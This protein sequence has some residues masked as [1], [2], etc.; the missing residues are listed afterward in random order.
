MVHYWKNT[1]KT[2]A[3]RTEAEDGSF[4]MKVKGEKYP[5]AA[6]PRGHI[7]FGPMAKLKEKVKDTVF[8]QI[9]AEM[10]K[11]KF[12]MPPKERLAPAVKHLWEI[13]EKLE[14]CEITEDMKGRIR[15]I[16][17]VVCLILNEDDAYRFRAQLFLW[18]LDQNKVKMSKADL[19][20]ARGKYFKPDRYKKV[21]GKVY[22]AYDY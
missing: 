12:D 16:R 5:L 9:F 8:N 2:D 19:Y 20:Y 18:L 1:D 21:L 10:E 6:F 15:L 14:Q 3:K 4:E 17:N 13:F 7:L 22:D 11:M